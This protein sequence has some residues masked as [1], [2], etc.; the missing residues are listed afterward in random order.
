VL[1]V[2]TYTAATSGEI[3]HAPLVVMR[4]RW[5][6]KVRRAEAAFEALPNGRLSLGN[7]EGYLRTLSIED[8][9]GGGVSLWPAVT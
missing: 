8:F 9:T 1:K 6:R 7:L 2:A 3:T 4:R 5:A